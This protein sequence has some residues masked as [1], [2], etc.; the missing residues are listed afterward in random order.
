MVRCVNIVT[1]N[2][3]CELIVLLTHCADCVHCDRSWVSSLGK[4]GNVQGVPWSLKLVEFSK[5]IFQFW[6]VMDSNV[7]YGKSLEM[8]VKWNFYNCLHKLLTVM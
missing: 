8:I 6:K 2:C 7:G 3:L 1:I 4:L 5:T